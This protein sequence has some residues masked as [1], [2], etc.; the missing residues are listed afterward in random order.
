MSQRKDS[1]EYVLYY[2]PKIPGRGEYI[3]LL[4]EAAGKPYEDPSNESAPDEHGPNGYAKVQEVLSSDSIG[5]PE[6]PP[7]F[8]PPALRHHGAGKNG[9]SLLLSQTPNVREHPTNLSVNLTV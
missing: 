5:N 8:A 7:V 1:Y 2:H 3:R 6:G 9:K 4:F